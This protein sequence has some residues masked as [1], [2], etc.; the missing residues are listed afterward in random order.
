MPIGDGRRI[1]CSILLEGVHFNV[2][3][4]TARG[5]LWQAVLI[6]P[7]SP[8]NIIK[9]PP[10]ETAIDSLLNENKI[11]KATYTTGH[12]RV[13]VGVSSGHSDKS[14]DCQ[15]LYIDAIEHKSEPELTPD[16]VLMAPNVQDLCVRT[17]KW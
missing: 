6:A 9:L 1:A 10:Q 3:W 8:L 2:T 4:K 17:M 5:S 13:A 12:Q 11:P 7:Y 14:S 15:H 16:I